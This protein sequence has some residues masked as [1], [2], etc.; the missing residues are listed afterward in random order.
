VGWL[1]LSAALDFG[2]ALAMARWPG[3]K[4][5]FL[6]LSLVGNLGLLTY[7]KAFAPGPMPPGISFYT[8]QTLSYT[9]DV[10][11]GRL[12]ARRDPWLILAYVAWFP[13]LLAG[14]IERGSDL[15]PQL[16]RPFAISAADV[17]EGGALLCSGLVQKVVVADTLAPY[18]DAVWSTAPRP[19]PLQVVGTAAF[20][21]QLFADF[22]GYTD[23]ARGASRMMGVRLSQNF[24]RPFAAASP[25]A[26]FAR[27]HI[28][29]GRL[30]R[31]DL[32]TPLRARVGAPLALLLTFALAGLWHG[33]G[34]TFLAWGLWFGLLCLLWAAADPQRRLPRPLGI[35]LTLAGVAV[36]M[37]LFRAPTLGA[38]LPLP[39]LGDP[40]SLAQAAILASLTATLGA[41]CLA[42][43]HL[44]RAP[45]RSPLLAGGL[46]GIGLL[47]LL[48][49]SATD[50]RPF[51][52]FQF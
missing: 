49:F 16:E 30:L 26:F 33:V 37:S 1:L 42:L 29:L 21:L 34:L 7:W 40:A 27:W 10:F 5:A 3:R 45:P 35:A 18:V 17:Q 50:Q 9:L 46:V 36:G 15:I 39:T 48:V 19:W 41:L 52:Y 12:A 38:A 51:V 13:Q 47:A 25:M 28:T 2:C 43:G 31:D 24:D 14:P 20:A 22:S 4:G 8:F 23:I 6:A 11:H 32:Y 44:E